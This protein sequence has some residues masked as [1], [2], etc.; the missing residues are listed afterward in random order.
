MKNF[1]IAP[2]VLLSFSVLAQ[3][4]QLE[5]ADESNQHASFLSFKKSLLNI[6]RTKD[7][8]GLKKVLAPDVGFSFG[9]NEEKSAV[10]GF[11]L[12]YKLA[13]KNPSFWLELQKTIDLGCVG[14]AE[15]FSCPY[16]YAN[17]PS[18]YD[19]YEHVA[20]T[21]KN[22]FVREKPDAKS[23]KIQPAK[24]GIFKLAPEQK[25]DDWYAVILKNKSIGFLQKSKARSPI[26]YR[27]IFKKIAGEWKLTYFI[28]GD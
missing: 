9:V 25:T 6:I 18:E 8:A 11:S 17:W 14:N 19:S 24:F 26:S 22:V 10:D 16:L 12:H 2:L 27:V 13:D 7:V 28:A 5:P 23:K 3:E 21:A 1:F 15:N 4:A 20:V